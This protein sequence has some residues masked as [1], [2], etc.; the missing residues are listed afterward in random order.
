MYSL[1]CVLKNRW[2]L[3]L[4]RKQGMNHGM[5]LVIHGKP[6]LWYASPRF[7]VWG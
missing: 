1:Q 7:E 5:A 2:T 4:A 3:D 6:F